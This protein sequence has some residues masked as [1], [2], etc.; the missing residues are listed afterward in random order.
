MDKKQ[1]GS[2]SAGFSADLHFVIYSAFKGR[3]RIR[4]QCVFGSNRVKKN[5][6]WILVAMCECML[7]WYHGL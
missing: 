1:C 3:Y 7:P 2:C 4:A 5:V 6:I